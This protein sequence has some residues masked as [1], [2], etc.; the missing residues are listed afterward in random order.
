MSK[1]KA[2][3]LAGLGRAWRAMAVLAV[4]LAAMPGAP[5]GA[6]APAAAD[7]KPHAED[8]ARIEDYLNGLHT[9]EA[10]IVQHTSQ[11]GVAEGT[12]YLSRPGRLRVEYDPPVP[13]LIVSDGEWVHYYDAELGQVN[14]IRLSETPASVLVQETFDLGGAL[15]VLDFERG[16]ATLRITLAVREE[17]DAGQLT[18]VFSDKPLALK[19]WRVVDAQG[20]ETTVSLHDAERDVLLPPALFDFRDPTKRPSPFGQR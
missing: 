15:K 19:Q 9:L 17:P 2:K 7:L 12:L 11:G 18:L 20:V 14:R 1:G 13:V 6:A 3:A 4:A 5:A 10:R 16:K 8:I